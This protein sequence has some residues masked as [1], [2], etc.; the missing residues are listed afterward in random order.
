MYKNIICFP[1]SS[2]ML[3]TNYDMKTIN[4]SYLI[5]H[6]MLRYYIFFFFYWLATFP[7]YLTYER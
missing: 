2:P 6:L 1:I 5:L 3:E 7:L 4:F